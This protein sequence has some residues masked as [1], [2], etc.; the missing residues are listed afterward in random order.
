MLEALL[1]HDD[2]VNRPVNLL[3]VSLDGLS[4]MGVHDSIDGDGLAISLVD[5]DRV[6]KMDFSPVNPTE[7]QERLY[8]FERARAEAGE[9]PVEG[10]NWAIQQ[11]KADLSA[12][13]MAKAEGGLN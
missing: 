5:L 11:Y 8:T 1:Q 4:V 3:L 2:G 10:C 6:S 13:E 7:L 9:D 12:A